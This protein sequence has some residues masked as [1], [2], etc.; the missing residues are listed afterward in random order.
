MIVVGPHDY[1][2]QAAADDKVFKVGDQ[3]EFIYPKDTH[4]VYA[5]NSV[6]FDN[7]STES[8]NCYFDSGDDVG[9]FTQ[10]GTYYFICGVCRDIVLIS[11]KSSLL[12]S[13]M[14]GEKSR[15][16]PILFMVSLSFID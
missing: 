9:T 15:Y 13:S 5:V 7:C 8:P 12:M 10:P 14:P 1:D 6:A 4:N 3:L 16:L 11:T 2:Y